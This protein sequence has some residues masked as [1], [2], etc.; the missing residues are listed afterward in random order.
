MVVLV[1]RIA[2]SMQWCAGSYSKKSGDALR[3]GKL[4]LEITEKLAVNLVADLAYCKVNEG[5]P[6]GSGTPLYLLGRSQKR[7]VEEPA[8]DILST[9]SLHTELGYLGRR[10]GV[11][12]GTQ[13]KVCKRLRLS[14]RNDI[15]HTAE[16]NLGVEFKL[17]NHMSGTDKFGTES[18]TRLNPRPKLNSGSAALCLR[19]TRKVSVGGKLLGGGVFQG[20]RNAPRQV[21]TR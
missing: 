2:V 3:G 7:K 5:S 4:R 12:R 17:P 9:C 15:A 6:S 14:R 21:K 10:S 8:E 13:S 19:L 1:R 11:S 18:Q 16:F 20:V